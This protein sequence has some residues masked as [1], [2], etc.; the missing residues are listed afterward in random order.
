[1][2]D[3]RKQ[4]SACISELY[5]RVSR[6]L[7]FSGRKM[8]G[9]DCRRY[10]R[11]SSVGTEKGYGLDG[12]GSIPS[13]GKWFVSTLQRSDCSGVYQASYPMGTGTVFLEIKRLEREAGHSPPSSAE[14]KNGGA[15]CHSPTRLHGTVLNYLR[16][17]TNLPYIALYAMPI[18]VYLLFSR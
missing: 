9:T 2:Y 13:K 15:I 3:T 11:S 8:F 4:R 6:I 17:A 14:V 18:S 1:M 10:S 12:R 5:R 7:F 16:S